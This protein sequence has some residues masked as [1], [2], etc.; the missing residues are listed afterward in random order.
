VCPFGVQATKNSAN[1]MAAAFMFFVS[2]LGSHF[3]VSRCHPLLQER[4]GKI[5]VGEREMEKK[6]NVN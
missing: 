3:C 6:V 1:I 4:A 2:L 5:A